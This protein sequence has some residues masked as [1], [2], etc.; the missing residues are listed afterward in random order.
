MERIL[1]YIGTVRSVDWIAPFQCRMVIHCPE[2][3]A[4]ALPGQFAEVDCTPVPEG[5]MRVLN[6]SRAPFLRRPISFCDIDV[7]AGTFTLVFRAQGA[8]TLALSRFR[9]G[10]RISVLGP[11]GHGFRIPTTGSCIAVGGGIG[12]YP[13]LHLLRTCSARGLGTTAICGYRSVEDAF[14]M[15]EFRSAA[16]ET[17]FASDSGGLDFSGHAAA[18]LAAHWS[19]RGTSGPVTVFTCGPVPMMKAVAELAET[20]GHACQVSLEERMGCGT[21]I[22]LVC[23]CEIRNRGTG[24]TEFKRCCTEGPV[25]E[26]GEVVWE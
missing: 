11:L 8:G 5:S 21:G 25:F 6:A 16:D 14:L 12:V 24:G 13:L 9:A 22:C 26:A 15:D 18:A 4:G 23:A 3:A 20:A 10:D 19:T 2:I 1:E 17:F 7:P